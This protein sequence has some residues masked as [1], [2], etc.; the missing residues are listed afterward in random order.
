MF[1]G[2]HSDPNILRVVMITP[3]TVDHSAIT[4]AGYRVRYKKDLEKVLVKAN[5]LI[6]SGKGNE[7]MPN[8]DF[9]YCAG[10]SVSA[11]TFVS[12]YGS[13]SSSIRLLPIQLKRLPVKSLIIAAG[14]DNQAPDLMAIITPHV[15]N[16]RI[17]LITIEDGSHF[18][19]DF[20]L[21]DAADAIAAFLKDNRFL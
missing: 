13:R 20:D 5:N 12:Y 2:T 21:M 15:D 6:D 1:A 10:A 8:T 4:P 11:K 3:S 16:K 18:L 19:R 7:I 14:E 9:L 17:K